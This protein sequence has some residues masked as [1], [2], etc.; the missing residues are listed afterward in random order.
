MG[1]AFSCML[2]TVRTDAVVQRGAPTLV[3][4][5]ADLTAMMDPLATVLLVAA[6]V[7]AGAP[8]AVAQSEGGQPEGASADSAAA[9][10]QETHT[11][12]G[13]TAGASVRLRYLLALPDGYADGDEAWPLV[14][15]LHGAGERGD[16][17]SS[18]TAHGP[19]RLVREGRRFPFIL[20]SP[21]SPE[22]R[23]WQPAE[24]AALVDAIESD[25]RVDPDRIY[26]TGLS[27]GGF[28]TWGLLEA[29]PDRFAAAAPVC[30]G[31]TPGKICAAREVPV[32]AFHGALDTVVPL[33]RSQEMV[34]RLE[35]CDGDVR[36]TVYPE[37]GHDSWT[38]TYANPELYDW[39]LSQRRGE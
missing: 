34:D 18:V 30:G 2:T 21:Q 33:V 36:L 17:L 6:L 35:R 26:V 4:P 25:Y 24:L 15:F 10:R 12:A 8:A 31:G 13:T 20:V 38:E 5:N 19:P 7:V 39:L 28:G 9:L 37:A 11:F 16:D 29:Y 23:W 3:P 1:H 22:E 14:L 27:M 32:W